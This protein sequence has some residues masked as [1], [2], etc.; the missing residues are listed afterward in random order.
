MIRLTLLFLLIGTAFSYAAETYSSSVRLSLTVNNKSVKDVLAEIESNS[1]YIFFYYDNALDINRKVNI[2]VKNQTVDKILDKLFEATDN[3]Y[4]IED[5]QII[6][7]RKAPLAL[8]Q[9]SYSA[10]SIQQQTR[11]VSGTVKDEAGET[12]IGVNVSVKGTT[13]GS[14]TDLNGRFSIQQ[15]PQGATL[16]VSYVGYTTQEIPV[17][18][19]N[20]FNITLSEDA[21]ALEEVV[22]VGYGTQRK[23]TLSGAV[24]AIRSEEITTTKTENLVTNLQGKMPGLLIRQQTGEPGVF[25]N[26][27]SIRG[28]GEPLV[29]IDGITRSRDGVAE[30]AQLNSEDVES[31]SILKDASAAIYGMNAANG[32]I[33]VT[34]KKGE[35]SK[36]RFSYSGLYGMKVPTGMELTVDAYTYRVM[37]NEMQRNIGGMPTYDNDLLEKYRTNAPGYQDTDWIGLFMYDMVPQQSH[38]ISVR[39][40]SERVRYFTSLNYTEDN[41]LLK[42]DIQYYRRYNFRTNLTADLTDDLTMNVNVSGRVDKRQQPREDFL[43]TYKTLT[44]NDRGIGWHTMANDKHYSAI[45]PENKNPAALVDPDVDGY[46]RMDNLNAQSQVELAYKAPFLKGLTLSLVGS[47]DIRNGN[48]SALQK[49]YNI[50]DYYTDDFVATFGSN[51]Y[52]NR[53]DLYQKAYIRGMANYLKDFGEHT[54]NVTGLVEASRERFDWVRGDRQYLDIFTHD[55]LNQGSATTASNDG[56]REFRRLAAYIGR[57]NYDYAEKYLV[58]AVIRYDGSYRYAPNKRWVLFPSVSVGW[59]L[60]EEAFIKNLLPFADNLKLRASYGESGRDTGD[61]FQYVAAYTGDTNRGY[62]FDEGS[63]TIGMYPPGV[64][65]DQ[66]SWVTSEISN[67]GIDF[68]FWRGKLAGSF[69]Y[70]QRKNTGI[71]AT[72]QSSVPNTFGA[73]FPDENIN[74]DMNMGFEIALNH[75]GKIGRDFSYSI[76]ANMTYSRTK[77]LHTERAPFSSQWD[78]WRNGN[79]NRLTGRSLIYTYDGQYTALDQYETAPLMGG[80]QGNSRILP[81]SFR[82]QDNNG[83]GRISGEDQLFNNWSYGETGYVSGINSTSQR[84]N[85]PLQ[86]GFTLAGNYKGFDLNILMQGAALYSIQYSMDDIWGYGRYP[87]L[88]KKFLDRWHTANVGDDPYDPATTWIAGFYPAIRSNRDNTTDGNIISVW[89]PQATYL[90]AKNIELGY[91]IPRST[92]RAIGIGNIRV[93]LNGTNLF[94]FTTRELKDADPERQENA[95]NANLAYPIMKAFNA[96]ININF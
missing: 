12:L 61:P 17:G 69:D 4:A 6:I 11:T 68:D 39:G 19:A 65:T 3:T 54:I 41:G 67:L 55:I 91:T 89:R 88:H 70:F 5:R 50:Y 22:V 25:D 30:L 28:Y 93:F 23:E 58:E 73:S 90:R 95:W 74:S 92:L 86:F 96:G 1:E 78:R 51:N 13:T 85:P 31:I 76:G 45:A 8:V 15:V 38:N 35:A 29:V 2:N 82:I 20:T 81:G 34:T 66:L 24:T 80:T 7:S 14:I 47:F 64:V 27:V 52:W 44:V 32:V 94:T 48:Q 9:P 72:R 46:R 49:S 59:R 84:V 56:K 77:R 36:A 53:I 87:T 43:W 40:G 79:E 60:S 57:V 10:A 62:V 63:L 37:A 26:M 42:S 33:I 18:N 75:R 21:Q 83:D 71:L 16:V